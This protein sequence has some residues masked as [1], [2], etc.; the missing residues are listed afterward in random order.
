MHH[1][2]IPVNTSPDR[3][4]KSILVVT[5]GGLILICTQSTS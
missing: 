2:I 3:F 5:V 4:L 1:V